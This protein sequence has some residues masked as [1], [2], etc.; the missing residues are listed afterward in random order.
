VREHEAAVARARRAG[1][2]AALRG[3]R[4]LLEPAAWPAASGFEAAALRWD[5]EEANLVAYAAEA[6]AGFFSLLLLEAGGAPEESVG[7]LAGALATGRDLLASAGPAEIVEKVRE[8][9]PSCCVTAAH[10]QGSRLWLSA[11]RASLPFL[12]RGSK[13]VRVAASG[14]GERLTAECETS[15]GDLAVVASSGLER[16]RFETDPRSPEQLLEELARASTKEPLHDAL[17]RT[18]S[19]W[20]A[21]GISPGPSDVVLLATRRKE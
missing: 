15:S 9:A 4:A 8:A 1:V 11:S 12:L 17:A 16:M 3:V 7:P 2:A 5:A 14:D 13:T 6:G 19:D 20:K 10:W 18:M 21:S